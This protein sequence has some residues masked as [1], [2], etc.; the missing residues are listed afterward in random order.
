M[1]ELDLDISINLAI[2]TKKE[3]YV[4]FLVTGGKCTEILT[5]VWVHNRDAFADRI[6]FAGRFGASTVSVHNGIS[7]LGFSGPAPYG[8]EPCRET[9]LG[10]EYY[11]SN[12]RNYEPSDP[13]IKTEIES[14]SHL[15]DRDDLAQF[16]DCPVTLDE[17]DIIRP[18]YFER[19]GTSYVLWI[20]KA[21]VAAGYRPPGESRQLKMSEYWDMVEQI[22]APGESDPPYQAA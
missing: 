6:A 11:Y 4:P 13:E 8:W 5:M 9:F 1:V 19:V 17:E 20:S 16:I 2:N 22:G 10:Y 21:D 3:E 12:V 18:P 15:Y 14:L 7:W